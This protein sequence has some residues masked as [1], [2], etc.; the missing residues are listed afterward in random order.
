MLT[1]HTTSRTPKTHR[2]RRD[3]VPGL[4]LG[5]KSSI[6]ETAALKKRFAPLVWIHRY[7]MTATT[8]H[9]HDSDPDGVATYSLAFARDD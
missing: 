1:E 7:G 5:Q 3:G 9:R 6:Q 4:V 8:A 2:R